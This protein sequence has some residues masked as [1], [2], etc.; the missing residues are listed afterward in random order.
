MNEDFLHYLWKYQKFDVTNLRSTAGEE[1]FLYQLGIHNTKESGPDFFNALLSI[2][3]QKWAGTVEIHQKSSDWYVH[4]HK[5]DSMYDNVILHVVWED[6]TEIYRKDAT[7]ISTLQLKDYVSTDVLHKY[8]QLFKNRSQ[9]WIVCEDELHNV[10]DFVISNWQERL[11]I[12]RLEQ[13][14]GLI[15]QLLIKSSNN[16]E[17]VLFKLLAKSFG[18]KVNGEAFLSMA[19]SINFAILRKCSGNLKQVESLFFGQVGELDKMWGNNEY[20]NNLFTEYSYLKNKFN[21][22]RIGVLPIQFFRLRPPNF[23]TI[24]LAQL[25]S[26]YGASTQLFQKILLLKT[27]EEFYEFF[28]SVEISEFWKNHY[29]FSKESTFRN[30]KITKPFVDLLLINTILPLKFVYSKT[31]G[32]NWEDEVL[33]VINQ[34]EPEKN[35]IVDNFS[36]LQWSIQNAMHSQAVLQLRNEYCDKKACLKCAIGNY[37]LTTG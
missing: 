32:K 29:T 37:L 18:S 20:A 10:S 23:P 35:K 1:I 4:H 21:L 17:E 8:L 16:W 25:A 13:K 33:V 12:E 28:E 22:D 34:I 7:R 2:N 27:K 19:E 5:K 30:K 36:N 9:K 11:Y 24:R 14:T 31:M 26:L 15:T 6:D 3:D